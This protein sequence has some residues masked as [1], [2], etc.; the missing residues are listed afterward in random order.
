MPPTKVY[1]SGI[2]QR[3]MIASVDVAVVVVNWNGGALLTR[4]LQSLIAQSAAPGSIIV[5]DNGSTDGSLAAIEEEFSNITILQLGENTGFAAALNRGVAEA[6]N[7]AWIASV[8]P[9]AFPTERW[10]ETMVVA[11]NKYPSVAGLGSQMIDDA[12]RNR[13]DGIGDDYHVSGLAWRRNHGEPTTAI[14]SIDREIFAPCAAAAFYNRQVISE[15]G[16]FDESFFCYFEDVDL[17]FRLRLAGYRCQAVSNAVVFH[18][19]SAITGRR[20]DFSIYHGHRNL[21]WS[22][23][24]NMPPSLLW[25]YLPQH[26]ILNIMTIVYYGTRGQLRTILSAKIDAVR[27]LPAI[28]RRRAAVQ[29]TREASVQDLRGVMARGLLKPYRRKHV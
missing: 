29:R 6:A 8:N 23:F 12:D 21:V 28:L 24:K 20:S 16:G 10:I 7:Y 18:I 11:V 4:C 26:F 9:D 27:G 1:E 13:L 2:F 15:L 22:F 19:G 17:G 25:R 14:D 5:V 3:H